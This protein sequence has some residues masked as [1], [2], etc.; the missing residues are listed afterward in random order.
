MNQIREML[1]HQG[2]VLA[3]AFSPPRPAPAGDRFE[4]TDPLSGTAKYMR[5]PSGNKRLTNTGIGT[6][7]KKTFSLC[8][9]HILFPYTLVIPAKA[10][11]HNKIAS[12]KATPYL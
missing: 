9:I 1:D 5:D 6:G 7:N 2:E 8:Q 11:I 3:V 12:P 10:G 4:N